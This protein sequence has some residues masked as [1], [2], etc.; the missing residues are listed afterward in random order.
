VTFPNE[1]R[2]YEATRA[3]KD[4]H[5]EFSLTLYG[6]AVVSKDSNGRVSIKEAAD[7]GPLAMGVGALVGGLIGLVAGPAG[8]A[9]GF[10]TGALV[11]GLNDLYDAGI[12]GDFLEAVWARLAPGQ[13]AVVA[14]IDE[15]WVTPL[16][17]RMEALGGT[18]MREWRI[19]FVDE[20]IEKEMKVRQVELDQLKAEFAQA[21]D[22]TKAK[23]RARKDEAQAKLSAAVNRAQKRIDQLDK[24]AQAK[25]KQLQDQAAKARGEAKARIDRTIAELREDHKWRADKLRQAWQ[26]TKDALAA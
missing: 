2:A 22:E 14:D 7:Q 5:N 3:L 24:E 21:R 17:T 13:T 11:G 19:N 16:D 4:L 26:L 15:D 23:L 25:I 1:S 12:G 18:V 9:V 20:Q 8:A 6:M 10:G